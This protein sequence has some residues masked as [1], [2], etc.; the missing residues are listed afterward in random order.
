MMRVEPARVITHIG[1]CT[2]EHSAKRSFYP[3]LWPWGTSG[4]RVIVMTSERLAKLCLSLKKEQGRPVYKRKIAQDRN[5]YMKMENIHV[6][7]KNFREKFCSRPLA[8]T[9]D[10]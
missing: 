5:N 8:P 1:L 4:K 7:K 2:Q 10:S 3:Q 6:R 9:A